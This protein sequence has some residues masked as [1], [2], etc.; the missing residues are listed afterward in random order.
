[1]KQRKSHTA[2]YTTEK[3]SAVILEAEGTALRFIFR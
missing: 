3:I 2:N 1:M